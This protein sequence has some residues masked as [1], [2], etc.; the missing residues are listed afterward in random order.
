MDL[1]PQLLTEVEFSEQWRGYNKNDVD[2]FLERVAMA[3]GELQERIREAAARA[4]QAEG[5]RSV[6]DDEI[7]RTLVLA[8]RAAA[9]AVEEAQ[10]EAT[11]LRQEAEERAQ[12]V[13]GDL[14][15]RKA[16]LEAELT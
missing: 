16:A 6:D 10:A 3:V 7:R 12:A 15:Q 8:Q 9:S 4:E 14:E 5:K 11:R 13:L 1:T 2:D